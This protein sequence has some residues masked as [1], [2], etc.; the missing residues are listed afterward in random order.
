MADIQILTGSGDGKSWRAV[1]HFDVP[2]VSNSVGVNIRTALVN[3]GIGLNTDTNRRTI[4]PDGDG[5][6]GTISSAEKALLDSGE[7]YEHVFTVMAESS[8]TT[9]AQLLATVR[10]YYAQENNRMQQQIS[11]WL[12]Y[13]G[14]SGSRS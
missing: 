2:N 3:S 11:E 13:F 4:L 5:T 8:G 9:N 7:R 12:R 10:S 1:F 6:N 14:F